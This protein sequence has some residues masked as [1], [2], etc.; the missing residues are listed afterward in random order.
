M[1]SETVWERL[2]REM[3]YIGVFML[4]EMEEECMIKKRA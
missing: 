4:Q 3:T 1:W 2:E